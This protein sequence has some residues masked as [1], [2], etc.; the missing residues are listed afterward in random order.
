MGTS[1]CRINVCLRQ[2]PALRS[3][4]FYTVFHFTNNLSEFTLTNRTL[5]Q[6]YVCA[7]E[8][9]IVPDDRMI[10]STSL[11]LQCTFVWVKGCD[12]RKRF[13]KACVNPSGGYWYTYTEEY[14]ATIDEVIARLCNDKDE[15]W[16]DLCNKPLFKT[17]E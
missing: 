12:I 15:W 6:Q 14:F 7:V 5:Y 4:A 17:T 1:S 11:H 2:A 9:N 10:P 16:C 13:H 8:S 3:L